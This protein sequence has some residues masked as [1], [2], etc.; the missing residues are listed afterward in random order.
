MNNKG[1]EQVRL[2]SICDTQARI[3]SAKF[4]REYLRF[5][6]KRVV[7]REDHRICCDISVEDYQD[8]QDKE[9]FLYMLGRI[10]EIPAQ[11]TPGS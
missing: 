1:G 4:S 7:P 11:D 2:I 3:V 5:V 6:S 8:L 9:K 10:S